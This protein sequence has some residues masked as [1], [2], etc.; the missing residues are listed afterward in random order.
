[1]RKVVILLLILTGSAISAHEFWLEPQRFHLHKGETLTLKFLV[2]QDFAGVN[3]KGNRSSVQRLT[4][5]YNGI[6]DDLE[7]LIPDSLGGDSLNLQ[8]FDEGTAM[9]AY[10][11]ANKSITL[12]PNQFL[13]YLK[14]DG[15]DSAVRYREEH[16][17]TDSS[18]REL[19]QRC[20]KTIFQVGSLK[21][22]AYQHICGLPAEFVPLSNPY[23]LKK[24]DSMAFK[25]LS[26]GM[27]A[28]GKKVNTWHRINGKTTRTELLSDIN[29]IVRFPVTLAGKW[30]VS[31]VTMERLENTENADWQSFWA[32]LTWGY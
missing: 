20:A 26:A 18:G 17:E 11:S 3:W 32:S 15:L 2:G 4:L 22:D 29:G 5:Y 24:G 13:E 30:M 16:Q 8:F 31:N 19:Y 10:Q 6:Q 9:I 14:E 1:M 27:P 12:P 23:T 28:V 7:P 25:I 21:N